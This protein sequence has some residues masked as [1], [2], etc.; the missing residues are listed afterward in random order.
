MFYQFQAKNREIR[1]ERD[2][3]YWALNQQEILLL[4]DCNSPECLKLALIEEVLVATD[5]AEHLVF[6]DRVVE[7]AFRSNLLE[8]LDWVQDDLARGVE[9]TALDCSELSHCGHQAVK[10]VAVERSLLG[11]QLD[12]VIGKVP[13]LVAARIDSNLEISAVT[14]PRATY[15]AKEL[16]TVWIFLHFEKKLCITDLLDVLVLIV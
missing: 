14:I 2:V 1:K 13:I 4:H 9:F 5:E 10:V 8:S 7:L 3:T 15:H 12:L 11:E 6:I 16:A